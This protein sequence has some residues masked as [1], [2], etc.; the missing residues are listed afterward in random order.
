[1]LCI[2]YFMLAT[3][4]ERTNSGCYRCNALDIFPLDPKYVLCHMIG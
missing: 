1:M 2:M 3:D 4:I